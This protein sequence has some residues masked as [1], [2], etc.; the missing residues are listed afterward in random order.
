MK[1]LDL[2]KFLIVSFALGIA[3]PIQ[4]IPMPPVPLEPI[5]FEPP[6]VD[7]TEQTY[8]QSCVQLD[9]AIRHLHPYRYSYKQGFY[10]DKYNTIATS[11][12]TLD[13]LLSLLGLAY[14]AYSSLV[15]EKE[16]RRMLAVEQKISMLQQV[17]A[18]KHCFE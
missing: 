15:E 14:L 18:E 8:Q 7:A 17:K 11:A 13:E 16:Q 3:S 2:L 4:A 1:V 6:I 9:N 5:Y 10:E 12:I